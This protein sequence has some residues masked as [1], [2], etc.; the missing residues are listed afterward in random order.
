MRNGLGRRVW[1]ELSQELPGAEKGAF[2][3]APTQP[4][5]P[6]A[7]RTTVDALTREGVGW[8]V[9]STP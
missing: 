8:P 9:P 2:R 1:P 5:R 4:G 3:K 7:L 6:S